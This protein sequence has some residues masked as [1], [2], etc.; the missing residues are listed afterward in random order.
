MVLLMNLL[1]KQRKVMYE[2]AEDAD[3]EYWSSNH[4]VDAT[5]SISNYQR[6]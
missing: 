6:N 4:N 5:L 2:T 3:Y 1:K